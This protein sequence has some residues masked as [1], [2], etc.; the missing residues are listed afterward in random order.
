MPWY[1]LSITGANF[2]GEILSQEEPIGFYT[3]RMV[4]AASPEEAEILG[5]DNLRK[6]P[7]L[8]GLKADAYANSRIFV[9]AIVELDGRPDSQVGGF[10]FF[11]QED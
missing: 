9:T 6:D 5:V 3:T 7:T 2:P 8:G 11:T 4:Q 10:S 1:M